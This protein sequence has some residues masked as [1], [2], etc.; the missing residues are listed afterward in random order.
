MKL[1]TALSAVALGS[2]LVNAQVAGYGQCGGIGWTGST[3]CA[4][5]FT[6]SVVNA[7]YSQCL[8]GSASPTTVKSSAAASKTTSSAGPSA[9]G[10]TYTSSFT[11]YGSTDSWGSGNCNVLTTACGY[12][13]SPGYNAAASQ[14]IFGVGGGVGAGPG[15]GGCWQ[16][17]GKTDSSGNA[18]SNPKTIVVKVTNLC[19]ASGNPLCAQSGLGGS[20]NQYGAE[21]NFDLCID[22]G[23]SAA[24]LGPSGVGLAVG[25]ATSVDCSAWSGTI[26]S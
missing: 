20:T 4:S 9:T 10:V 1:S 2:A 19:P 3:T 14:N 8:P 5:S 16:L 6:C 26:V 18:L 22:S 25:T 12:Y 15:C 13:T 11:E 23:A 24:F 17:T 21:V 7:Y